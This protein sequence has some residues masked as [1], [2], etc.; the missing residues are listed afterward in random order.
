MRGVKATIAVLKQKR[1]KLNGNPKMIKEHRS[2][3]KQIKEIKNEALAKQTQELAQFD[4]KYSKKQ[5][6]PI[7][8]FEFTNINLKFSDLNIYKQ[9]FN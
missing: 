9:I 7:S 1:M 3:S 4:Q 5:L 2:I 6:D 8:K